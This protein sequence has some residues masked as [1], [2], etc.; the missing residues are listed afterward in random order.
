MNAEMWKEVKQSYMFKPLVLVFSF[1][2]VKD[3]DSFRENESLQ[4]LQLC[5]IFIRA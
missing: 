5:S 3:Q 4:E 1:F 2:Q